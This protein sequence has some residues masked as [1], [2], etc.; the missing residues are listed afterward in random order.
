MNKEGKYVWVAYSQYE[1]YLPVATAV[2][3]VE[4]GKIVGINP[5]IIREVYC[6]YR[7]GDV[8]QSRFHKVKIRE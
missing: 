3:A 5:K 2:S 1:P 6:H 4:L 8:K 7:R